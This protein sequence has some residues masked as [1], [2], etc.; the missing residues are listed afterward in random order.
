MFPFSAAD[1]F[2]KIIVTAVNRQLFSNIP[3]KSAFQRIGI[4]V[5]FLPVHKD[6]DFL[7]QPPHIQRLPVYVKLEGP[8]SASVFQKLRLQPDPGTS[9][10]FCRF[11]A[12]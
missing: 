7:I 3:Q 8:G 5:V 1:I 10:L 2:I 9:W 12:V 6:K 11:Y 4:Y